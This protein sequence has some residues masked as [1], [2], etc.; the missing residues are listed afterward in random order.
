LIIYLKY[1]G[2]NITN[3][4]IDK[5]TDNIDI[6]IPCKSIDSFDNK[7]E[8]IIQNN[9]LFDLLTYQ[10]YQP[11][12]YDQ[13]DQICIYDKLNS[14]ND[15]SYETGPDSY[16]SKIVGIK[17]YNLKFSNINKKIKFI[18]LFTRNEIRDSGIKKIHKYSFPLPTN[19][20]IW[21][22]NKHNNIYT[23]FNI[24]LE[25]FNLYDLLNKTMFND[26]HNIIN[27]FNH[28]L[29]KNIIKYGELIKHLKRN[30]IKKLLFIIWY[31]ENH[32]M[33]K[34]NFEFEIFK[35]IFKMALGEN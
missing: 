10:S 32:Y 17:I 7:V 21:F 34:F 5:L 11:V 20:C 35:I 19:I 27:K 13:F 2:Y 30:E 18:G 28:T 15:I 16:D 6:F 4:M 25:T 12:F 26:E 29:D 1:L 8:H 3:N 31:K 9:N 33:S 22:E 23:H 14:N 24:K